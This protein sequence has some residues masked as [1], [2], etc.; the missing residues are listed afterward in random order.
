MASLVRS[1]LGRSASQ[2]RHLARHIRLRFQWI[3][4]S[5]RTRGRL[6]KWLRVL[7]KGSGDRRKVSYGGDLLETSGSR[8]SPVY[9]SFVDTS[10]GWRNTAWTAHSSGYRLSL[11][12][13]PPFVERFCRMFRQLQSI[14]AGCTPLCQSLHS[15]FPSRSLGPGC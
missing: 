8:F 12:Q 15:V 4:A 2:Y 7:L 10:I 13:A 3:E 11:A 14:L 5:A 9:T 1:L 6:P